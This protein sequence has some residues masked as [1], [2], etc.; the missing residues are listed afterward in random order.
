ME[1]TLVMDSLSLTELIIRK[2][3][4]VILILSIIPPLINPVTL[5]LVIPCLIYAVHMLV[6]KKYNLVLNLFAF[7]ISCLLYIFSV[8]KSLKLI[9][10][11][12]PS[13]HN[14]FRGFFLFNPFILIL[15]ISALFM[16]VNNF[17]YFNK[18]YSVSK[19]RGKISLLIAVIIILGATLLPLSK[20]LEIK[21]GRIQE[22]NPNGSKQ[23]VLVSY[24]SSGKRWTYVFKREN[25]TDRPLYI[26]KIFG[27]KEEISLNDKRMSITD[28]ATAE[29]QLIIDPLKTAVITIQSPTPLYTATFVIENQLADSFIFVK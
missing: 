25:E 13:S 15:F 27:N 29:G 23:N 10:F 28:A 19:L 2:L 16:L 17:L 14:D 20:S 9:L 26:Q 12:A 22:M 4:G 11:Y 6:G 8:F 1:I 5:I 18:R 7:I 3:L 24:D 21:T